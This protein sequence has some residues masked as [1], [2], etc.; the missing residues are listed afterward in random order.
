M[1]ETGFVAQA[2]KAFVAGAVAVLGAFGPAFAVATSDGSITV[3]EVIP[4]AVVALGLGVAAFAA[5]WAVPNANTPK[6]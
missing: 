4:L 3:E 6:V 1:N 5:T 2:R